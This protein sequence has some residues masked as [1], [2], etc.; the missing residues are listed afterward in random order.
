MVQS[1]LPSAARQQ[2]AREPAKYRLLHYDLGIGFDPALAR[3]RTSYSSALFERPDQPLAE[4]QDLKYRRIGDLAGLQPGNSILEIGCGWGGFMEKAARSGCRV[5]G[6]TLSQEQLAYAND[7][8]V[9]QGLEA[10]AAASLTDYRDTRGEYDAVVSIEMLEVVGEEHW[11]QYFR[12][13]RERLKP[14]A[15]AVVQVITIAEERFDAYRRRTDFIQRYIFP[16]GMLPTPSRPWDRSGGGRGAGGG[17]PGDLRVV[18]FPYAGGLA[19]TF[20]RC[21]GGHRGPGV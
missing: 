7:R 17:P 8:M 2:P 16:G 21:L 15:A 10:Q 18:L 9:S 5:E 1:R 6:I 20:P 14:G 19:S 11:P 12:T 13:L 4:A 3:S